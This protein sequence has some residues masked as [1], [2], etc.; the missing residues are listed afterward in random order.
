MHLPRNILS[1]IIVLWLGSEVFGGFK[2]LVTDA[3]L[4]FQTGRASEIRAVAS[5][6]RYLVTTKSLI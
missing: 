2:M 5:L 4:D 1:Y 6:W 3:T